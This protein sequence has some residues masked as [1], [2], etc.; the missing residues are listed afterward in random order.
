M[1]LDSGTAA[2]KLKRSPGLIRGFRPRGK[3]HSRAHDNHCLGGGSLFDDRAALRRGVLH[4]VELC[5]QR[6][7][8][9]RRKSCR[10]NQQFNPHKG[11]LM[12]QCTANQL[13]VRLVPPAPKGNGTSARLSAYR[14]A[15]ACL[16]SRGHSAADAAQVLQS[17]TT[18][19]WLSSLDG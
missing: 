6:G 4:D 12:L 5:C 10:G 7:S 14:A 1:E 19:L 8:R 17:A 15:N 18:G 16:A 11:L 3:G 13:P 2:D 9:K